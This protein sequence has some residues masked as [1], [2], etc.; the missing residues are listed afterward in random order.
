MRE[1]VPPVLQHQILQLALDLPASK[2][3]WF[4]VQVQTLPMTLSPFSVS[5]SFI[6]LF[7]LCFLPGCC[8]YRV[9]IWREVCT[10]PAPQDVRHEPQQLPENLHTDA[11][12]KGRGRYF[13]RLFQPDRCI[14]IYLLFYIFNYFS[15]SV[16][17]FLPTGAEGQRSVRLH[18]DR[19]GALAQPAGQSRARPTRC[20]YSFLGE[21][22]TLYSV[23]SLHFS[24]SL[25][26][27]VLL[28]SV[29]C[30]SSWCPAP[31]RTRIRLPAWSRKQPTCRRTWAVRRA[32]PPVSRCH[33]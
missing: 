3:S 17:K 29:R 15:S 26:L 11:G 24:F 18:V 22:E 8:R 30:L 32:T 1:E 9:V 6:I 31:A 20:H 10:L 27:N 23:C 4:R 21:G 14:N 13:R 2:F 16:A 5:F 28:P 12:V 19:A 7:R 33:T 25:I